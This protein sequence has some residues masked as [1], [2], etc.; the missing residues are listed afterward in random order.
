MEWSAAHDI[1]GYSPRTLEEAREKM[2][3]LATCADYND[4]DQRELDQLARSFLVEPGT[5][6]EFRREY[7]DEVVS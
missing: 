2:A 4:G 6:A 3:Y 1:I 7:P 5:I